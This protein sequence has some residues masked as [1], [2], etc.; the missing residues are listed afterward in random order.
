MVVSGV[1]GER[2]GGGWD[3]EE[4]SLVMDTSSDS[5]MEGMG[6]KRRALATGDRG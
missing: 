1:K 2:G 3:S 5:D 4:G 6:V